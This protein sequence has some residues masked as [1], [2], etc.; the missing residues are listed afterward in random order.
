MRCDGNATGL[1]LLKSLGCG[2]LGTGADA[3]WTR[4]LPRLYPPQL[5][6]HL[7]GSEGQAGAVGLYAGGGGDEVGGGVG[8]V[9]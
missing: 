3:I 1:K 6:S 9:R 5:I 2:V 7:T 8:V 4:S